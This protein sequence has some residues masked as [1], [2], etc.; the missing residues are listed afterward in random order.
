MKRK[1]V[2]HGTATLTISLPVQW[3][4]KFSI[5][6]GDELDVEERG[7]RIIVKP[8]NELAEKE[9]VITIEKREDFA[10]RFIIIPYILGYNNIKVKFG[11]RE[12]LPRLQE[13]ISNYIMGFEIVE[14]GNN[15]CLLKNIARGIEEEFEV[16]LN[17]LAI[18]TIGM[19]K[20]V[21]EAFKTNKLDIIAESKSSEMAANKISLFCRRM[22]NI[23]GHKD[24]S[25]TSLYNTVTYLE[26][27]TDECHYL[28][29]YAVKNKIK[30]DKR[31]LNYTQDIIKQ[32][33]LWYKIFNNYKQEFMVEMKKL[34]V[35]LQKENLEMLENSSQKEVVIVHYLAA[36]Q[37]NL[38]HMSE[39][40]S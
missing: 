34:E 14:Q 40:L 35:R 11:E 18:I 25:A 6:Q 7:N 23:I 16:M 15:Y 12:I 39:E 1:V 33:E 3:I 28:S 8:Y 13:V 31:M 29:D 5:K 17:R 9:V 4:K 30:V 2:K 36:M 24:K 22:L 20:D 27:L 21:H 38:H 37:E 19:L 32:I 10:R 26:E